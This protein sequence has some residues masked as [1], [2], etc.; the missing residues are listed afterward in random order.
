ME[1]PMPSFW[2]F[3]PKVPLVDKEKI[4][5]LDETNKQMILEGG[6]IELRPAKEAFDSDEDVDI[7][8]NSASSFMSEKMR[9]TAEKSF[10]LDETA[11]KKSEQKNRFLNF[12]NA[13][14][15]EEKFEMKE[16]SKLEFLNTYSSVISLA[17]KKEFESAVEDRLDELE[18]IEDAMDHE[19]YNL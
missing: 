7:F 9:R 2:S 19:D 12:G 10:G 11:D 16:K 6:E 15:D 13:G 14:F 17:Q 18:M 8:A 3:K 4:N 5:D 1:L